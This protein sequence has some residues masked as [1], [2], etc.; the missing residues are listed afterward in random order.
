MC[1]P[2]VG[3]TL[4]EQE[5]ERHFLPV[6]SSATTAA[7]MQQFEPKALPSTGTVTVIDT[8]A[9]VGDDGGEEAE[10]VVSAT[11]EIVPAQRAGAQTPLAE[12]SVAA[13]HA[14]A[15]AAPVVA[16]VVAPAVAPVAAAQSQPNTG[17]GMKAGSSWWW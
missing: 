1:E 7:A 9:S 10:R 11:G 3:I 16:P 13:E 17:I 15:A 5:R 8:S 12:T 2:T 14:A 6:N 4:D